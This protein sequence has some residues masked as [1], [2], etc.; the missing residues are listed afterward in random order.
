MNSIS[1]PDPAVGET[2]KRRIRYPLLVGCCYVEM[3]GTDEKVHA[4]TLDATSLY[5]AVEKAMRSWAMLWWFDGSAPVTVR[6]GEQSWTVSMERVR[7]WRT[8]KR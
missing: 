3:R 5:D 7:L 2:N 8:A 4:T 6:Y 1:L